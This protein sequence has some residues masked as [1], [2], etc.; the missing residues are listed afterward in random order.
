MSRKI[1]AASSW[2]AGRPATRSRTP[3]STRRTGCGRGRRLG[4]KGG[5]HHD[6]PH[7]PAEQRPRAGRCLE[8]T[9]ERPAC[10]VVLAH[11]PRLCRSSLC[12]G[13]VPARRYG[14]RLPGGCHERRPRC[15][16][17]PATGGTVHGGQP[18][19]AAADQDAMHRGGRPADPWAMR[20]GPSLC[21]RR[22]RTIS[23]SAV[24]GTWWGWRW[25]VLGRSTRPAGR[26]AAMRWHK[27]S[28]PAGVRRALAWAT[29]TS[30]W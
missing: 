5:G 16:V 4:G 6:Q 20:A 2:R 28:L 8:G 7:R 29:R 27:I 1:E 12:R 30:G 26:P 13:S 25:A 9:T 21:W 11:Q 14:A 18:V 24:A 10:V 19:E 15:R 17:S 3:G 22:S 23:A